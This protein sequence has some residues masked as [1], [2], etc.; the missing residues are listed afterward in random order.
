MTDFL[1][2]A[3]KV[4]ICSFVYARVI[5]G[6]KCIYLINWIELLQHR[7]L[8]RPRHYMLLTLPNLDLDIRW[9]DEHTLIQL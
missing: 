1:A 2:A 5:I 9:F 3:P 4:D 6:C 8:D 7:L